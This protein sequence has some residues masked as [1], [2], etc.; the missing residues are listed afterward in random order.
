MPAAPRLV[1][2]LIESARH[3][4]SHRA[5]VQAYADGTGY[6]LMSTPNA[7]TF[8]PFI[9][10]LE[11][12]CGRS[13]TACFVTDD[14]AIARRSLPRCL[15]D[16]IVHGI[17]RDGRCPLGK[18]ALKQFLA[19]EQVF[20]TAMQAPADRMESEVQTLGDHIG[21]VF[22]AAGR[23][24]WVLAQA[25]RDGPFD[26]GAFRT[27]CAY[28]REQDVGLAL[29]RQD[30]FRMRLL[31]KCATTAHIGELAAAH[32]GGMQG[33]LAPVE[34]APRA[35]LDVV[36]QCI[37]KELGREGTLAGKVLAPFARAS[38]AGWTLTP[39]LDAQAV[40]RPILQAVFERCAAFTRV[41]A[42]P[43]DPAPAGETVEAGRR[44]QAWYHDLMM[45]I[46]CRDEH[47]GVIGD[48]LPEDACC[49]LLMECRSSRDLARLGER[50]PHGLH[51]YLDL[52]GSDHTVALH[53]RQLLTADIEAHMRKQRSAG[54]LMA[55]Y[56][57][58]DAASGQPCLSSRM[59]PD[60]ALRRLYEACE[61]ADFER[62]A[63]GALDCI[64]RMLHG[65]CLLLGRIVDCWFRANGGYSWLQTGGERRRH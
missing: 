16:W 26:A 7:V 21:R 17:G 64:L 39:P 3:K 33:L 54:G 60:S 50:L 29:W 27:V 5:T 53:A 52:E 28:L 31:E 58:R 57:K 48:Q 9:G 36:V 44:Y 42:T 65:A 13:T 61:K 63:D 25:N 2:P 14:A 41:P 6:R 59:D 20:V 43:G 8:G 19:I 55:P 49:R 12:V 40:A 51:H 35:A 37:A 47:G 15:N 11:Y 46:Q 56:W 10:H 18:A 62:K 45:L 38:K 34:A 1:S 23:R 24:A 32:P 4:L 22:P 30:A